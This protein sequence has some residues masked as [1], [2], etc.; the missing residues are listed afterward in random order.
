MHVL[1]LVKRHI[2]HGTVIIRTPRREIYNRSYKLEIIS[3]YSAELLF[4]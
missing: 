1:D 2:L 3:V 4:Y